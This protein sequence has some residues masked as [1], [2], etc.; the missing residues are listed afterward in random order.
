MS[1]NMCAIGPS[2]GADMTTK[3]ATDF[4]IYK[5]L[6]FNMLLHVLFGLTHMFAIRTTKLI[7]GH[8][9][10]FLINSNSNTFITVLH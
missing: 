8:F 9:D 5:V 6:G 3:L 10:Q 4:T 1:I 7:A 2:V